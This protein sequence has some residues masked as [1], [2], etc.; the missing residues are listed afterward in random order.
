MRAR[1]RRRCAL[2]AVSAARRGLGAP[3]RGLLHPVALH[4]ALQ[5]R[6][7]LLQ[8]AHLVLNLI[9]LLGELPLQRRDPFVHVPADL[10]LHGPVAHRALIPGRGRRRFRLRLVLRRRLLLERLRQR[11]PRALGGGRGHDRLP[12]LVLLALQLDLPPDLFQFPALLLQL[13]PLLLALA[14]QL[15]LSPPLPLLLLGLQ[16]RLLAL[17]LLLAQ[18]VLLQ[19]L[20]AFLL[21]A[22]ALLLDL[23]PL[24]ALLLLL[25]ADA[26]LFLATPLLLE[27]AA[28]LFT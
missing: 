3:T 27:A 23:I 15:E 25:K 28:L 9:L 7:L 24:P 10:L 2:D 21:E 4:L 14:V 16:A 19:Q 12:V 22:A 18:P 6:V 5:V 13:L 11:A 17:P 1:L 26:L 20:L 8:E